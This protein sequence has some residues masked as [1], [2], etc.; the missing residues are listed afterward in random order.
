M[1]LIMCIVCGHSPE[2]LRNI[3][4]YLP[5]K[6]SEPHQIQHKVQNHHFEK[7]NIFICE[8]NIYNG[9]NIT[10]TV[11][12]RIVAPSLIFSTKKYVTICSKLI[13]SHLKQ[14]NFINGTQEMFHLICCFPVVFTPFYPK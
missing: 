14:H 6:C 3:L 4:Q 2:S 13:F 5:V 11:L 1:N 10:C 7:Y 9:I 12:S 8:S